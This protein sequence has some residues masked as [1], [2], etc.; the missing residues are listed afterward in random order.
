MQNNPQGRKW[1]ITVNNPSEHELTHDI[2]IAILEAFKFIYFCMCD[3]ISNT[4]TYHTHIFIFFSSPVRFSTLKKCFPAAHIERALGSCA[5]NR[6]Y[7]RKEGRWAE[8]AKAE[9]S[10]PETFLEVGNIP[11]EREEKSPV[12]AEIIRQLE[13]GASTSEIIKCNPSVL[14]RAKDIDTARQTFLADEYASKNRDIEVSYIYG[15][16][17]VGKTRSIFEYYNAS[18]ICRI[19]TY[20][21]KDAMFDSYNGQPVLVMEEFHSQIPIQSMLNYLDRY[22]VYLPARYYDRIACYTK[23]YITSNISLSEQYTWEQQHEPEIYEAFLRRI[24]NIVRFFPNG[25]TQI[26]KGGNPFEKD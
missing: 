16:T 7:L 22:P 3:E 14:F 11:D 24:H 4:G 26:E 10:L 6:D 23:L 1:Q 9:T 25:E 2:I 17:G 8:T 19:T 21:G 5:E 20:R 15:T 13:E 12:M 18:D